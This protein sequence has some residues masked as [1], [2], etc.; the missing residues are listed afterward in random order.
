MIEKFWK[1]FQRDMLKRHLPPD[2]VGG[3][4]DISDALDAPSISELIVE[5][6]PSFNSS[7]QAYKIKGAKV[8]DFI[9]GV[10]EASITPILPDLPGPFL[11]PHCI[12]VLIVF[13]M[14]LVN[15]LF[16]N[17]ALQIA[18]DVVVVLYFIL[19]LVF[20]EI[21][22][23]LKVFL[24]YL[25]IYIL[26]SPLFNWKADK[27]HK[28]IY[29]SHSIGF[30]LLTFALLQFPGYLYP[31]FF[32][33]LSYDLGSGLIIALIFGLGSLNVIFL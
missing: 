12:V 19:F 1:S 6:T 17:K 26:K 20:F 24:F 30:L 23:F 31:S 27:K 3:D 18:T 2:Q 5:Y 22:F 32:H 11:I 9:Q 33:G 4:V 21:P 13:S 16:E 25:F 29:F 8:T 7:S 15:V 14:V 28:W 10:N